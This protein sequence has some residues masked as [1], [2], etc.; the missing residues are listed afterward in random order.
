MS[1]DKQVYS[2]ANQRLAIRAYARQRGLEIIKSYE[3]PGLSGLHLKHR[4]SLKQL[5]EDVLS[6][7]AL[8]QLVLVYDVSRWGRF[9][10]QDEAATYEFLC[11][12]SGV[13]VEYCAEPF[14]SGMSLES[15]LM[16][17][18]K[19]TMAAEF[20]RRLSEEIFRAK[21]RAVVQGCWAGGPPPFGFQRAAIFPGQRA[22]RILR[23]GEGKARPTGR[24][25]LVP[26]PLQEVATVRRIFRLALK[27]GMSTRLIAS[28]LNGKGTLNR[29]KRWNNVTIHKVL[30]SPRYMG[31]NVWNRT[32]QRLGGPTIR[33]PRE[34]W[35][36]CPGAFKA[37]VDGPIF[38]RVQRLLAR[39]RKRD[40]WPEKKILRQ[41][42]KLFKREGKITHALLES[43]PGMPKGLIIRQRFG[44][45]ERACSAVGYQKPLAEIKR[46]I[47]LN[48]TLRMRADLVRNAVA[49]CPVGSVKSRLLP[50]RKPVLEF[51]NGARLLVTVLRA[52][53]LPS[54]ALR[55][56]MERRKCPPCYSLTAFLNERNDK[57]L[58]LYVL[59]PISGVNSH[60][61][62]K[63]DPE[64]QKGYHLADIC[65]LYDVVLKLPKFHA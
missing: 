40:R 1:T 49:S 61:F 10:D 44:S 33:V 47:A 59:P 62:R 17:N 16:K 9:E 35:I 15:S 55:W 12:S 20:S 31:T 34:K 24:E 46:G 5:L 30:T 8:Y 36:Y 22:P 48:S 32:S 39:R 60:F 57:I 29:G 4:P 51:D 45:M 56:S 23:F 27:S 11:R 58:Y 41:L 64:M 14:R 53:R 26:G 43:T 3:D 52:R 37:I 65:G 28:V 38:G 54:N 21:S 63:Q 2:I 18:L 19:R 25:I 7:N 6:G 50:G 13:A 42:R